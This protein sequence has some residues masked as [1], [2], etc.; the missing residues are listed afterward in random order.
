MISANLLQRPPLLTLPGYP[1]PLLLAPSLRRPV[2][3][4][5]ANTKA[6]VEKPKDVPCS[7][8]EKMLRTQRR[9]RMRGQ[10]QQGKGVWQEAFGLEGTVH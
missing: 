2:F 3:H 5:A 7:S 9:T 10:R 4:A 6:R 8:S 1:M